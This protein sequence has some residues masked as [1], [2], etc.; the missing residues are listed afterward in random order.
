MCGV[1]IREDPASWGRSM[2]RIA[3]ERAQGRLE[4]EAG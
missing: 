4:M 2:K 3:L 1:A